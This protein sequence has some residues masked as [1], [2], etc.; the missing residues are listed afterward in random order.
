MH[1][2]SSRFATAI[3]V[4]LLLAL[5]GCGKARE[6]ESSRASLPLPIQIVADSGRATPL[7]VARPGAS[8]PRDTARAWI[9]SVTRR[10][11]PPVAASPPGPSALDLPPPEAR[12]DT[13]KPEPMPAP[14]LAT[15]EDLKP[16]ILRQPARLRFPKLRGRSEWVE[17]DVRVDEN[18]DVSDAL[19][20]G[21][22]ADS[23]A[24]RATVECAL[25]M[26]FHPALQNGR[27]IPVWCRQRFVLGSEGAAR[28]ADA[29]G[30]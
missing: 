22:S 14:A 4:G 3:L 30:D 17:L 1:G 13:L 15:D 7:A 23:S 27:P 19:W 25:A 24:V 18:G 26:K 8:A 2:V 16:P 12:L 5:P 11:P 21:G 6:R 29:S 10:A 20:A 28:P 9:A